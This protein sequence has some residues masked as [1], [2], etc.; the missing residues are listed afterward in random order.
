VEFGA[1]VK[2]KRGSLLFTGLEEGK[3]GV[4]FSICCNFLTKHTLL[5]RGR[6]TPQEKPGTLGWCLRRGARDAGGGGRVRARQAE[7]I[8]F[9]GSTIP[10]RDE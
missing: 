7:K 5:F 1:A 2:N 4:H 9:L 8:M 6:K 3:G 10:A